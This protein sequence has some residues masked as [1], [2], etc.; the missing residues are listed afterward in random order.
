MAELDQI[1]NLV[2]FFVCLNLYLNQSEARK[3]T[4]QKNVELPSFEL[5]KKARGGI[6]LPQNTNIKTKFKLNSMN[7][8]IILIGF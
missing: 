8:I 1:F 3:K 5:S 4:V 7:L 6:I 2:D